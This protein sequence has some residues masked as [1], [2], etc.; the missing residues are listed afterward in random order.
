MG[1][2]V[3][4]AIIVFALL[5]LHR[6]RRKQKMAAAAAAGAAADAEDRAEAWNK[7]QIQELSHDASTAVGLKELPSMLFLHSKYRPD[8]RYTDDS[9]AAANWPSALLPTTPSYNNSPEF[10]NGEWSPQPPSYL[11]NEP[12]AKSQHI[13]HEL[14]GSQAGVEMDTPVERVSTERKSLNGSTNSGT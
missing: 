11:T 7:P 2:I 4:L 8:F 13:S 5:W 12:R 1:G 10:Q 3:G 14:P 9:L 6:R